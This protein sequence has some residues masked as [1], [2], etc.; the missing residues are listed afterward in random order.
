[1]LIKADGNNGNTSL[2]AQQQSGCHDAVDDY[3]GGY[4]C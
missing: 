1:M 3:G 4:C 2:N